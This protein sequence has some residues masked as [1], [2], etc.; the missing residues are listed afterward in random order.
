MGVKKRMKN[1]KKEVRSK[2]KQAREKRGWTQEYLAG[3]IGCTREH[4][5]KIENNSKNNLS[6]KL[7]KN[8]ALALSLKVEEL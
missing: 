8:L 3:I 6:L 1:P 7:A 4:L 5:N 2:I